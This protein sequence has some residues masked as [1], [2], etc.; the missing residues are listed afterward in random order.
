MNVSR[1]SYHTTLCI[2]FFALFSTAGY[3]LSWLRQPSHPARKFSGIF[4][5]TFYL[6]PAHVTLVTSTE[7]LKQSRPH[8]GALVGLAPPKQSSKPSQ[9]ETWNIINRWNFGEFYNVKS[10]AQT[11]SPPIEN[12]LATV[13]GWNNVFFFL[14]W[15]APIAHSFCESCTWDHLYILVKTPLY[16][17]WKAQAAS[18]QGFTL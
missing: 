3:L 15:T 11:Q 16:F 18:M 8:G 17:D 12:F 2:S 1:H 6:L 9:I 14:Q 10:P 13:L 7:R 5:D 4:P